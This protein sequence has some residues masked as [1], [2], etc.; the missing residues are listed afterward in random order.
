MNIK[1]NKNSQPADSRQAYLGKRGLIV[2]IA[3]MNMFVPLSTDMYLPALPFMNSYFGCSSAITNLTLSM[4]FIFY[5]AGILFWGPLSDKY[6]RKPILLT[7][8]IIYV[9]SSIAC[10]LSLDI[11]FLI[12]TRI[13]QGIGAGGITSVSIAVIKDS[14][15]YLAPSFISGSLAI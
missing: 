9:I 13:F 14:F 3:L 2:F 15:S 11:Y 1:I 10:A 5:A 7:G 12:M 6:G 4:F 8:S